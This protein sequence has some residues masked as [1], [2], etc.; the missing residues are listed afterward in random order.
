LR[1]EVRRL[2]A[3]AVESLVLSIE[4]FNRPHAGGRVVG[5]LLHADHAFEMLLKAVIRHRGGEIREPDQAHTIGFRICLSRCLT[6]A[7]IK[8]LTP[9]QA[10]TLQALNGWRDAAQHYLLEL[11]EQELYLASQG[12]VTLFDDI[13]TD[14][15]GESLRSH[16]PERVLPV[17]TSPPHDI[18]LLLDEEFTVISELVRPG[19]RRLSDAR[20]RLRPVAILDAA[21]AGSDHQPTE[22]ELDAH[23][24]SLRG[25][26][27]WR[28][29]FPGVA[30][31]QLDTSGSGLTYSLRL[32]KKEGVPIHTVREGDAATAVVAVR[33]VSE[34][35]FYQFGFKDLALRLADLITP[36]KLQA[37]I[38]HFRL[39]EDERFFTEFTVGRSRFGR[40]SQDGLR[41]L[42]DELRKV[43][44]D[45]IWA[46]E[47]AARR[48][49]RRR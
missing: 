48:A 17:S 28:E 26:S 49:K 2:K 33:R 19:S 25:G 44:I 35:G 9:E 13:L 18:D 43:D 38:K 41:Y 4:L 20:A 14:V 12:A 21:T 6:T 47:L 42:R 46:S 3:K 34:L 15:F 11:S 16:V 30:A 7:G 1:R 23:I 39:R 5:V 32:T 29:L 22:K 24:R 27:G 36:N 40:Y 37:A 10:V 8:C 31:I 45:A